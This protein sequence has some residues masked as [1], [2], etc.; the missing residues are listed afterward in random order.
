MP[1]TTGNIEGLQEE[2]KQCMK[3]LAEWFVGHRRKM[4]LTDM[5]PIAQKYFTTDE[6]LTKFYQ[7]LSSPE[8]EAEFGKIIRLEGWKAGILG[9]ER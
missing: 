6:E 5:R 9:P 7:Y 4:G 8:G 3:E 1:S 2:Y